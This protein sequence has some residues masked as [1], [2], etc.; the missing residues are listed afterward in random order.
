[1]LEYPQIDPLVTF[2]RSHYFGKHRGIV[3]D[4]DDPTR[5]GRLR[6]RGRC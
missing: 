3:T 2:A 5:R 4:N 6:I 1:M